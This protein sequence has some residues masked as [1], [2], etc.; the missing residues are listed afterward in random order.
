MIAS[1]TTVGVS[2]PPTCKH[3]RLLVNCYAEL[4]FIFSL[5]SALEDR[6]NNCQSCV[7]L[8]IFGIY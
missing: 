7:V 1:V 2:Q 6:K 3:D 5:F 4:Q 8:K